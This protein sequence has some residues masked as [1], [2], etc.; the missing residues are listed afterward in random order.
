VELSPS[1]EVLYA[2][3]ELA[4]RDASPEAWRQLQQRSAE[5]SVEQEPLEVLELMALSALRRGEHEEAGR[6]L[7]QALQLAAR[8][9]NVMEAR[10]RGTRQRALIPVAG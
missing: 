7:E 10:L 4:T 8:I 2:M 5:V 6:I 1:E 3:V 9:P